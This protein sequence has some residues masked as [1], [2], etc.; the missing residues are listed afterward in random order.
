M[1]IA[2]NPDQA[3]FIDEYIKQHGPM[4]PAEQQMALLESRDGHD[5]PAA[6]AAEKPTTGRSPRSSCSNSRS[7][8][9][10]ATS[11]MGA[12]S[13]ARAHQRINEDDFERI[14]GYAY[15]PEG[16]P[17]AIAQMQRQIKTAESPEELDALKAGINGQIDRNIYGRGA[18]GLGEA[19]R[20]PEEAI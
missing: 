8:P 4:I 2:N 9:R 13:L 7:K 15:L 20:R 1:S 17:D 19:D 3:P 10:T 6:G 11:D 18:I 14:A 16:N 12:L 5:A